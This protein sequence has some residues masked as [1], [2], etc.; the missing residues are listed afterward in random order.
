MII[1]CNAV[2]HSDEACFILQATLKQLETGAG[3][4]DGGTGRQDVQF[5][6]QTSPVEQNL[7]MADVTMNMVVLKAFPGYCSRHPQK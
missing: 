7:N 3:L 2:S 1:W 6:T 4:R 5:K